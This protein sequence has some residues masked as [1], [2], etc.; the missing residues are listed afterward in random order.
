MAGMLAMG[1]YEY[2]LV[3]SDVARPSLTNIR[4][5]V[6]VNEHRQVVLLWE[7]RNA[8]V[9]GGQ[10]V[11]LQEFVQPLTISGRVHSIPSGGGPWII[12][13]QRVEDNVYT[14]VEPDDG[15][16]V[17]R[18]AVPGPAVLM[19]IRRGSV[20]CAEPLTIGSMTSKS[21]TQIVD[22]KCSK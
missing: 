2:E 14:D 16:Y 13:L 3:R 12:R 8:S 4:G 18:D 1:L 15:A 9:K 19:V 17:F 21:A 22:I 10:E 7:P 5:T 11:S 6:L 20:V